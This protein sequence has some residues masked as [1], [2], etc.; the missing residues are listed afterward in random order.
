MT[1]ILCIANK[2]KIEVVNKT[3]SE[4]ESTEQKWIAKSYVE[5][6][7]PKGVPLKVCN[8]HSGDCCKG[9][10]RLDVSKCY[11]DKFMDFGI[12]TEGYT[13]YDTCWISEREFEEQKMREIKTCDRI[14]DCIGNRYEDIKDAHSV[15]DVNV[16]HLRVLEENLAKMEKEIQ[17]SENSV[18]INHPDYLVLVQLRERERELVEN[19]KKS[20]RPI[21]ER[22]PDNMSFDEFLGKFCPETQRLQKA[23][24]KVIGWINANTPSHKAELLTKME[25]L[26]KEVMQNRDVINRMFKTSYALIFL[27]IR[28]LNRILTAYSRYNYSR[29]YSK[30]EIKHDILVYTGMLYYYG[31]FLNGQ[32]GE[33]IAFS[34]EKEQ[35]KALKNERMLKSADTVHKV[36]NAG[37]YVP[38]VKADGT[39]IYESTGERYIVGATVSASE[40]W[41][42]RR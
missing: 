25:V 39:I 2:G 13:V 27:V 33:K 5:M 19:R 16:K 36:K 28:D 12:W 9:Q 4:L 7:T 18:N 38:I 35:E 29:P 10:N 42:V 15:F 21:Y 41:R 22:N 3:T 23:E 17:K 14:I 1:H 24:D 31:P 30:S 8:W 32:D 37:T 26:K 11:I 34:I 20:L 40:N 6:K